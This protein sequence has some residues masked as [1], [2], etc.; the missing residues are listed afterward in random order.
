MQR[1]EYMA[2][3]EA[4]EIKRDGGSED[5]VITGYFARFD[6]KYK[7]WGNNTESIDPH[8][9]DNTLNGDVVSLWNHNSDIPLGRTTNGN[10][11][12]SV[13]NVGLRGK[14]TLNQ[15]DTDAMNA[16]AR[17]K[18]GEVKQCSFGFDI[19]DEEMIKHADD[20]V[21]WILREVKLYEVSPVTFPAYEKTSIEAR[22]KQL[23]DIDRRKLEEK[24]AALRE[25]MKKDA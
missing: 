13:D 19:L 21:E 22:Q 11:E 20:S 15:D 14:V 23:E 6:D 1:R 12:L 25:R 7:L 2:E 24:R 8:A 18:R 4:R 10:L 5:K 17:I 16:Y 9:F 3:F